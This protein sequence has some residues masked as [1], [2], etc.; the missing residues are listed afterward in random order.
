MDGDC[1]DNKLLETAEYKKAK[2]S[3]FETKKLVDIKNESRP[4]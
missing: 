3:G 1:P 4:H 2:K